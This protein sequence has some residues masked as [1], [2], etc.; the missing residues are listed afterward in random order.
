MSRGVEERVIDG[1]KAVEHGVARA[2]PLRNLFLVDVIQD[3][4]S[5]SIF[6][7]AAAALLIGMLVYHWLEGWSL[8]DALYFSVVTLAT[9][10]YG[11]LVPTTPLA[12]LFTIFYVLNGVS[13]LVALLDRLRVVRTRRFVQDDASSQGA[14]T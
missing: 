8:F 7:W 13:I 4:G 11:D 1:A 9:V 14:G 6:L 10:G 3:R 2:K 5:R 12:K